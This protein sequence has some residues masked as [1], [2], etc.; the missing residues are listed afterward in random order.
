MSRGRKYL[1]SVSKPGGASRGWTSYLIR[2][3]ADANIKVGE[4]GLHHIA[5]ENIESFLLGLALDTLR[6]FSCLQT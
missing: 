6:D 5:Q 2:S 1:A 3:V 4:I